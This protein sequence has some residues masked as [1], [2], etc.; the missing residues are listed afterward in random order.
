MYKRYENVK[1][2]INEC[3]VKFKNNIAYKVKKK[4]ETGKVYYDEVT[5]AR[6]NDEIEYLGRAFMKKGLQGKRIAVIGKNSYEWMV[7]YLATLCS[8]SIIV[9]LD[10]GLLDFEIEEQLS[11]S[12]ASA[13]FFRPFSAP[14]S[15]VG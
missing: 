12:E 6:L 7:V 13:I 10:R 8:G 5:Y 9:P 3:A 2:L 11:R 15:S 14:S 4:D 1:Q